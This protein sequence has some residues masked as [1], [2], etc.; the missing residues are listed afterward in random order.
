MNV[1]NFIKKQEEYFTEVKTLL[2]ENTRIKLKEIFL[3]VKKPQGNEPFQQLHELTELKNISKSIHLEDYKLDENDT[4]SQTKL[5]KLWKEFTEIDASSMNDH[6]DININNLN[7]LSIE[8]INKRWRKWP[9]SIDLYTILM[10]NKLNEAYREKDFSTVDKI[11]QLLQEDKSFILGDKKVIESWMTLGLI[12]SKETPTPV[13][14]EKLPD[15]SKYS[16]IKIYRSINTKNILFTL[17]KSVKWGA[18]LVDNNDISVVQEPA[19]MKF[20]IEI[21]K[22][23]K[24]VALEITNNMYRIMRHVSTPS[25]ILPDSIVSRIKERKYGTMEAYNELFS[26]NENTRVANI[27]HEKPPMEDISVHL[28]KV[29]DD[30][31]KGETFENT[32]IKHLRFLFP[33]DM[34]WYWLNITKKEFEKDRL[35][36]DIDTTINNILLKKNSMLWDILEKKYTLLNLELNT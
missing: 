9:L 27:A 6:I 5:N 36:N 28:V 25:I 12:P 1:Y 32:I 16:L 14:L 21:G 10:E 29:K 13:E 17:G 7:S 8:D 34:F 26:L 31:L 24:Y 11:N 35:N 33:T 19:E 3:S 15:L 2:D 20:D 4:Y 23:E 30:I 22:G 18:G